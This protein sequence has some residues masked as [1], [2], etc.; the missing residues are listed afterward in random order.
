[1]VAEHAHHASGGLI[2]KMKTVGCA[3]IVVKIAKQ[4]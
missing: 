1:M 3:T 2:W 4:E